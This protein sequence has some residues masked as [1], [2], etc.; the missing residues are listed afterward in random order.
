MPEDARGGAVSYEGGGL[1]RAEWASGYV[2]VDAC[3]GQCSHWPYECRCNQRPD[4]LWNV[5]ADA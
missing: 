5:G 4:E 2:S 3:R 1:H